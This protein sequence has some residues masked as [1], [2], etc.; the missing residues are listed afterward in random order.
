MISSSLDAQQ[1]AAFSQRCCYLS[2]GSEIFSCRRKSQVWYLKVS[3]NIPSSLPT[4][5]HP[6]GSLLWVLH[7]YSPC[8]LASEYTNFPSPAEETQHVCSLPCMFLCLDP[9]QSSGLQEQPAM[10]SRSRQ[11][12]LRWLILM[13]HHTVPSA[14][15]RHCR[16][17]TVL[18][19]SFP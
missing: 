19:S 5:L 17:I 18:Y 16:F 4:F 9:P 15:P 8:S 7:A 2:L 6:A 1:L 3:G 11:Q 13:L 12:P 10:G 14:V